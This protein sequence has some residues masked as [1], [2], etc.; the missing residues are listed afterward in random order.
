L[1]SNGIPSITFTLRHV[2]PSTL[3]YSGNRSI[4]ITLQPNSLKIR[5]VSPDPA[6]QSITVLPLKNSFFP[7]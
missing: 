1:D 7:E 5:E 2:S 3:K 6:G 4:A